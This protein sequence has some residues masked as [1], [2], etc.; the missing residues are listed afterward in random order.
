MSNLANQITAAF[1]AVFIASASIA[2]I[3]HV[4]QADGAMI[5]GA[6]IATLA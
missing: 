6:P 5:A 3:V 1:A 4:P 2:G